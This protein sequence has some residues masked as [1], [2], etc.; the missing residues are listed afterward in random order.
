MEPQAALETAVLNA[1]KNSSHTCIRN[2]QI[3]RMCDGRPRPVCGNVFISVWSDGSRNGDV[4]RRTMLPEI[5][6]VKVTATVRFLVPFDRRVKHRDDLEE[7][8]N[9][10]VEVVHKD[11]YDHAI[12]NAANDLASLEAPDPASQLPAGLVEALTFM[13][14]EP[15][16]EVGPDWFF[17]NMEVQGF[18]EKDFGLAQTVNFGQAARYRSLSAIS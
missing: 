7:I 6:G 14:Y 9:R 3:A 13:N 18:S 12:L 1:L 10:V 15:V 8:L 16:M 2:A 11:L 5:M 17:T 4:Q